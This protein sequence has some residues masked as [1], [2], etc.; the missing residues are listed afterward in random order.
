MADGYEFGSF[1]WTMNKLISRSEWDF[2]LAF[3]AGARINKAVLLKHTKISP[4]HS[5]P[6]YL[7]CSL[8][9]SAAC[10]DSVDNLI[11]FSLI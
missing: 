11:S 3:S 4:N 7:K 5:I 10:L 8:I 1:F 6:L 2:P 9:D